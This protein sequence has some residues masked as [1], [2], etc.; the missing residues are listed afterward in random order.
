MAKHIFIGL[1]GSGVNTVA[2]IKYKIYERTQPI[3]E[4]S[5]IEVMEQDYRFMYVDTD[6]NDVKKNNTKF[7]ELFENGR[8]PLINANSELIDIGTFNPKEVYNSAKQGTNRINKRIIESCDDEISANAP[9]SNVPLR[10]G[11]GAIRYNSRLAF[12]LVSTVFS[13]QLERNISQ[14]KNIILQ[15]DIRENIDY[16]VVSSCNG[17]TGSGILHEVLYLINM[18]HKSVFGEGDPNII[19]TLYMPQVFNKKNQGNTKYPLN[20]MATLK[21]IEQFKMANTN[22]DEKINKLMHRLAL[23]NHSQYENFVYRPFSFCIPI[24]YQTSSGH[25]LGEPDEMYSNTSELLFYTHTTNAIDSWVVNYILELGG[26]NFLVPMGYVALRKPMKP[27][28]DY[29]HKR[30]HYELMRYGV[31]GKDVPPQDKNNVIQTTYSEHIEKFLFD[32]SAKDSVFTKLMK[33]INQ[34]MDVLLPETLISNDKENKN[35]WK[36]EIALSNSQNIVNEIIKKINNETK[37]KE[38][39]LGNI[40]TGLW[41][42]LNNTVICNG[43]K[44]AWTL[45][46]GLDDICTSK[47][48]NYQSNTG[49]ESTNRKRLVNDIA[50]CQ[51]ELQ[52]LFEKADKRILLGAN[53]NIPVYFEQFKVYVR[54]QAELYVLDYL[55][56]LLN[57]LCIDDNGKIDH[58]NYYI[59]SVLNEAETVVNNCKYNLDGLQKSFSISKLDV[60]TVFLPEI[61]KFVTDTGWK[62]SHLFADLYRQIIEPTHTL[63]ADYG[64]EPARNEG[65]RSLM[66]FIREKMMCEACKPLMTSKGY[67][68]DSGANNLFINRKVEN[69]KLIMEDI[70]QFADLAL[71]ELISKNEVIKDRWLNKKLASLINELDNAALSQISKR[72]IPTLFFPYNPNIFKTFQESKIYVS[73]EDIARSLLGY[74]GENNERLENPDTP[75]TVYSIKANMGMS[76]DY[77]IPYPI[78]EQMYN[79]SAKKKNYHFHKAIGDSGGDIS[80]LQLPYEAETKKLDFVR[81]MIMNRYEEYLKDVY[82]TSDSRMDSGRYASTPLLIENN[83]AS[84]FK[85]SAL[86][87]KDGKIILDTG[88]G[89]ANIDTLPVTNNMLYSEIY[90]RFSTIYSNDQLQRFITDLI[91]RMKRIRNQAMKQHYRQVITDIRQQVTQHWDETE[92]ESEKNLMLEINEIL[93][94]DFDNFDNL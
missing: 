85:N 64:Y 84:I 65:D 49:S 23:V 33:T 87:E 56:S 75:D 61:E 24:D 71:A 43:Y 86:S 20:A 62:N 30:L 1:G 32:K 25:Y 19:L 51:G 41:T 53:K 55:Y 90:A 45:F 60:T 44:Y 40:N 73:S 91:A 88:F 36:D 47:M 52:D 5:R 27:F 11:A 82:F 94:S 10:D 63:V 57:E 29:M 48:I 15:S 79:Q 3:G 46:K 72:M 26:K 28:E 35:K 22:P 76:F 37:N 83:V 8:K 18:T 59:K 31:V 92:S 93:K 89:K 42:L 69:V 13:N 38:E 68:S 39:V 66:V 80:K 78:L 81:F 7:R 14:L 16:W 34:Q 74:Q 6:D 2:P 50:T 58:I 12:S 77:Y 70:L 4:L 17:G 9:L 54:K 67:I 21:E